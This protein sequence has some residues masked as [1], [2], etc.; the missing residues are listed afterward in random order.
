M[1]QDTEDTP[2]VAQGFTLQRVDPKLAYPLMISQAI[3]LIVLVAC[4]ATVRYVW[5]SLLPQPWSEIILSVLVVLTLIRLIWQ[6][7]AV[8]HIGY[9]RTDSELV[10]ASGRMFQKVHIVPY[11]RIQYVDIDRGPLMR[12][13]KLASLSLNTAALSSVAIAGIPDAE[14]DELRA[15][16]MER[17]REQLSGV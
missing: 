8:R 6:R 2:L 4:Y 5:P 10:I 3:T 1:A 15:D 7:I 17:C 11:G 16:L 13:W 12:R 9:V 14:C